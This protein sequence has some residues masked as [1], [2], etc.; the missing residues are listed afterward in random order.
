M[1]ES[2]VQILFCTCIG[3]IATVAVYQLAR[4]RLLSF[5]YTVGWLVLGV[6]VMVAGIAVPIVAPVAEILAITPAALIAIGA[7]LL[8][9]IICIQL[10]ISISGI[11]EHQRRLTEELAHLRHAVEQID[12]DDLR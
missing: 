9:V 5:R 11:Y 6:L 10:S 2:T 12:R 8:F 1:A 3:L 4:H 7:V